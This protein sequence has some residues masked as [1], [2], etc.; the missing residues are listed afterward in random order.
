MEPKPKFNY[1]YQMF[2]N[3]LH[4]NI[5]EINQTRIKETNGEPSDIFDIYS[6]INMSKEEQLS[7]YNKTLF[8]VCSNYVTLSNASIYIFPAD[9][10]E[11]VYLILDT[12]HENPY[13]ESFLLSLQFIYQDY[14]SCLEKGRPILISCEDAE[15][16]SSFQVNLDSRYQIMNFETNNM[17]LLEQDKIMTKIIAME[18]EN[19]LGPIPKVLLRVRK[20]I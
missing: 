19:K 7:I 5:L 14:F 12:I 6:T 17:N 3:E 10:L 4:K 13:K 8:N 18:K 20:D 15:S 11:F 9:F 1:F 2:I 16:L